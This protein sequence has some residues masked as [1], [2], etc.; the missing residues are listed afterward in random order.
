MSD[1]SEKPYGL[2]EFAYL[3]NGSQPD[4]V[5]LTAPGLLGGYCVFNSQERRLLHIDSDEFNAA[6]CQRMKEAG[7]EVLKELPKEP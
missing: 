2:D 5:L 7:C 3:W 6:L 4:W 1:E